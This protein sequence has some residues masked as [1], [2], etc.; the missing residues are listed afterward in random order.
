MGPPAKAAVPALGA[1]LEDRE[2]FVRGTAASALAQIGPGARP[3]LPRLR[4]AL[5]DADV[6]VRV[7]AAEALGKVGREA[8]TGSRCWRRPWAGRPR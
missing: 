5:G 6:G 4:A 1:A 3:A 8:K 7:E 2:G